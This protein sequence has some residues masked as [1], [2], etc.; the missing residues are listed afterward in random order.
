MLVLGMIEYGLEEAATCGGERLLSPTLHPAMYGSTESDEYLEVH[1]HDEKPVLKTSSDSSLNKKTSDK[2]ELN[3]SLSVE[4]QPLTIDRECEVDKDSEGSTV[5]S[6]YVRVEA[7]VKESCDTEA[8][9][10]AT[11]SSDLNNCDNIDNADIAK[12]DI[13]GS[14]PIGFCNG[15]LIGEHNFGETKLTANTQTP[16]KS[17][18]G[19]KEKQPKTPTSADSIQSDPFMNMKSITHIEAVQTGEII[20]NNSSVVNIEEYAEKCEEFDEN[21]KSS[22]LELSLNL[23]DLKRSNSIEDI[24]SPESIQKIDREDCFSWEE[25]SLLLTIDPNLDS[26]GDHSE[27]LKAANSLAEKKSEADERLSQPI[28]NPFTK[29]SQLLDGDVEKKEDVSF[30]DIPLTENNSKAEEKDSPGKKAAALKNKLSTAF[31]GFNVKEKIR[32]RKA[33]NNKMIPMQDLKVKVPTIPK[34]QQD[35]CGFPLIIFTKVSFVVFLSILT[36][37]ISENGS[38]C[39]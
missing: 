11:Q 23:E 6:D 8:E 9:K 35:D 31:G 37:N 24:D 30:T 7:E 5:G 10:S 38:M 2:A 16:Q 39:T 27:Q 12:P 1:Y 36:K 34:L 4:P 15:I 25:D 3:R 14:S 21:E 19:D 18:K 17:T 32:N 28:E 20:K 29:T 33:N 26:S 13:S 22:N